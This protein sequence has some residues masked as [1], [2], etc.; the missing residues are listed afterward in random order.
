[1]DRKMRARTGKP[2]PDAFQRKLSAR[3]EAEKFANNKPQFVCQK[4]ICVQRPRSDVND[5]ILRDDF[6][7]IVEQTTRIFCRLLRIVEQSTKCTLL[8]IV[9]CILYIVNILTFLLTKYIFCKNGV[10]SHD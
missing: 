3:E 7:G 5:L 9:Y 2:R 4:N 1:M 10:F 8:C 6:M